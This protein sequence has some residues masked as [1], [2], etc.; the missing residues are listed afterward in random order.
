MSSFFAYISRMKFIRR[1]GLMRNIH[2]ENIQE[3]SMQVA[4]IAHNLALVENKLYG[5]DYD[6]N[7]IMV[8]AAYHEVS[9]IITGD[10]PTPIKYYNPM[11]MQE[12][13]KIEKMANE[14]IVGMLPDDLTNE[15]KEIIIQPDDKNHK[16][17]KA[18]DK[19]AAYIKCVEELTA[20]NHEFIKAKD[21][22]KKTI[23]EIELRSVKYFMD[24]FMNSFN[25]TLDELNK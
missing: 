24:T 25:L 22:L 1:W 20:G 17:V 9:E 11:I 18:A 16:I 10:L 23:D 13:K 12:Y 2:D 14:K 19:I 21:S 3:H 7:Y 6:A 15:Y 5:G 8:L 4:M